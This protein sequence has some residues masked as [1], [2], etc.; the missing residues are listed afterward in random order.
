M[1]RV[2]VSRQPDEFR[3]TD[4]GVMFGG[5]HVTVVSVELAG[6]GRPSHPLGHIPGE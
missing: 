4:V 6:V 1:V 3:D 2:Q 5:Q